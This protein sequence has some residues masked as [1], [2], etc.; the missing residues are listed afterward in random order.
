M[1][2]MPKPCTRMRA[3]GELN[4]SVAKACEQ[5]GDNQLAKAKYPAVLHLDADNRV[6]QQALDQ[7]Q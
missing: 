4:P 3:T 6:A 2:C 1:R 5:Q 7:L